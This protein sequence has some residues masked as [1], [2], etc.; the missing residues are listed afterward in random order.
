MLLNYFDNKP[1]YTELDK[2]SLLLKIKELCNFNDDEL[3]PILEILSIKPSL[4]N[5]RKY[6][7]IASLGPEY[8]EL[9][10]KEYFSFDQ[11]ALI[12]EIKDPD[13]RNVLFN[14]L[15]KLFRFNT[16]E[17]RELIREIFEISKRDN[18]SYDQCIDNIISLS[19][20]NTNKNEIKKTIRFIRYP[21]LVKVEKEFKSKLKSIE[22][23]DNLEINHHP[24]FE[25][26]RVEVKFKVKDIDQFKETMKELNK[27]EIEEIIDSLL[28]LVKQGK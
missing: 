5:L 18:L 15:I 7:N 1:R 14:K 24:F 4:N 11:L 3:L 27:N 16:N 19:G 8:K 10:Y 9:F 6:L 2:A 17:I 23:I 28:T 26:N 13:F 25:T 22:N 12:S 21:E 20:N